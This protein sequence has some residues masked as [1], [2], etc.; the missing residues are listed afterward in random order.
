MLEAP[1]D[2]WLLTEA[3]TLEAPLERLDAPDW[4]DDAKLVVMI[5]TTTVVPECVIVETEGKADEL[6]GSGGIYEKATLEGI[7]PE[8]DGVPE[9]PEETGAPEIPVAVPVA[10]GKVT[11]TV[12]LN[13]EIK[14]ESA[15][16]VEGCVEGAALRLALAMETW[17]D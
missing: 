9:T 8:G 2:S 10:L 12:P 7:S 4:T 5:G 17:L 3:P 14:T 1:L 15:L 16:V 13:A 11:V 6:G